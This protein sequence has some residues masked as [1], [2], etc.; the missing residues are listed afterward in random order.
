M[1]IKQRIYEIIEPAQTHDR[2]SCVFDKIIL[3]LITLNVLTVILGS[4]QGLITEYKKI[5]DI[6]EIISI[7]IFTLEYLLRLYTSDH[8]FPA[9]SKWESLRKYIVSPMAVID[10]LA[11]LP[12]YIPMLI[13]IDLRF[14]RVLRLTKILRILKLNRYSKSLQLLGKILKNKRADLLVT[15]FVTTI[16]I[17]FASSLMYYIENPA[18]PEQFP[19][20]VASFWW[21]I[22]TLT[23]V[24][25]GDLYPITILGKILSGVI[26]LLGI[27]LVALPT[28]IIS[29]GFIEELSQRKKG[30]RRKTNGSSR[31]KVNRIA[32]QRV[33]NE[34]NF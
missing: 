6:F 8:K 19:N 9:S 7:S 30:K 27:G 14:L 2:Q 23:T 16:L 25:Y 31:R 32:K 29:S 4:F 11:I 21:A 5:F 17:I 33:R 22:T 1:K 20:I 12:F 34:R 26:A 13:P 24:G 15:V 10:L 18:Q 3:A 28:G